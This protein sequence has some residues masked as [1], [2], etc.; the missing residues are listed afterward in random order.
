MY[1]RVGGNNQL[2][3]AEDI[4]IDKYPLRIGKDSFNPSYPF[5]EVFVI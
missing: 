1:F 2:D 3:L 5:I 4:P